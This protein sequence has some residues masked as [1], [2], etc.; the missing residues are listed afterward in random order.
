M[1]KS[2]IKK[3]LDVALASGVFYGENTN[4][5]DID[6]SKETNE[7]LKKRIKETG[8][9]IDQEHVRGQVA[10]DLSKY[11]DEDWQ[12]NTLAYLEFFGKN[13]QGDWSEVLKNVK[14]YKDAVDFVTNALTVGTAEH[15]AL[16]GGSDPLLTRCQFQVYV[17]L[18]D[19]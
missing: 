3:R 13:S 9:Y 16:Y 17:T 14:T 4:I 7:E 15:S 19:S 5:T 11:T 18:S 6:V 1:E 8:A 2:E 10:L 12:K